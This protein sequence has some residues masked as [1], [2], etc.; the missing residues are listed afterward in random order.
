MC[1][2]INGFGCPSSRIS[3]G[4]PQIH[5][6]SE[7]TCEFASADWTVPTTAGLV[8]IDMSFQFVHAL[9]GDFAFGPEADIS[10]GDAQQAVSV[11]PAFV[12]S[13][14]STKFSL[15]EKTIE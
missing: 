8:S 3:I 15:L 7:I 13:S 6:S 10:F 1:A 14:L 2:F 4:R 11:R 12:N 5:N 9:A